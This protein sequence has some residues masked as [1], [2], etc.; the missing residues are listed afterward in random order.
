MAVNCI[1][2]GRAMKSASA[3]GMGPKCAKKRRRPEPSLFADG[4]DLDRM[5][6]DARRSVDAWIARRASEISRQLRGTP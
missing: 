3:T 1:N 6:S 5:C 2:C 4:F